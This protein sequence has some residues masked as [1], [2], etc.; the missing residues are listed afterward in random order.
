MIGSI[1]GTILPFIGNS[2]QYKK[3]KEKFMSLLKLQIVN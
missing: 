1:K 2:L 3:T